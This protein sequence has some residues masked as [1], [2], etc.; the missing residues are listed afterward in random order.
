M[1]EAQFRYILQAI[2]L[3]SPAWVGMP[4]V[5]KLRRV[6]RF[7]VFEIDLETGELRKQGRKISFQEQPF[8]VL[9][10]LLAHPG[11]VVMREQLRQSVWS[12]DTFV[13]FD[14]GLNTAINK[15]REALA[16]SATNPR[17]I[18]TVP[19]RGYRFVA[20]MEGYLNSEIAVFCFA[21]QF[22]VCRL[23]VINPR[24][25]RQREARYATK[26]RGDD[27][28]ASCGATAPQLDGVGSFANGLVYATHHAPGG[29]AVPVRSAREKYS[30]QIPGDQLTKCFAV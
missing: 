27:S 8:R 23:I 14:H 2:T 4:D 13:D 10:V 11:H 6:V 19:R 17:F 20:P 24:R 12:A 7:G 15:I 28:S 30:C 29:A 22:R 9:L 5:D 18:E 25:P 3:D 16:D 26:C 1:E 21:S